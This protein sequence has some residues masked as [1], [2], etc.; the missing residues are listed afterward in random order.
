MSEPA[1]KS[2]GISEVR[3]PVKRKRQISEEDEEEIRPVHQ[4][5]IKQS[6][7]DRKAFKKSNSSFVGILDFLKPDSINDILGDMGGIEIQP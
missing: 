2:E 1:S 4:E 7:S 6:K 3:L 5:V